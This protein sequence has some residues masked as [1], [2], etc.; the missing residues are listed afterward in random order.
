VSY[1]IIFKRLVPDAQINIEKYLEEAMQ[2]TRRIKQYGAGLQSAVSVSY[3]VGGT[4]TSIDRNYFDEFA[5]IY[6]TLSDNPVTYHSQIL[7]AIM[8]SSSH[9]HVTSS[10][11]SASDQMNPS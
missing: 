11:V 9:Q 7:D 1:I 4:V 3:N 6:A 8:T 5:S 2:D 10:V